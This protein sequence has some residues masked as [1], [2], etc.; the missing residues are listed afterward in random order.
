MR[1]VKVIQWG[2]VLAVGTKLLG[3]NE[4]DQKKENSS[5]T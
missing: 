2:R 4:I 1:D 5:L 3:S